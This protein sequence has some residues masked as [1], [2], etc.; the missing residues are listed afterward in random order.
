MNSLIQDISWLFT[1]ISYSADISA[2]VFALVVGM[3]WYHPDV[4]GNSWMN[5][6]GLK[7][8]DLRGKKAR[9]ALIWSVP[10]FLFLAANIAAFCKHF[11]W[12]T[13]A[14]GML[15]GYDL[16]IMVCLFYLVQSLYEQKP[17]KLYLINCGYILLVATGM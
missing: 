16:G 13:G 9:W 12:Y 14:K 8:E 6:A 11:G 4:F 7:K 5:L 3:I 1:N 17:W 15:F 2:T 10:I